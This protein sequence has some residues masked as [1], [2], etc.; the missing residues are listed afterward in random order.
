MGVFSSRNH[1]PI[2]KPKAQ[3]IEP[4]YHWLPSVFYLFLIPYSINK[5]TSFSATQPSSNSMSEQREPAAPSKLEPLGSGACGTVWSFRGR[6]TVFK[7]DSCAKERALE[8]DFKAF[9][10][11]I[12]AFHDLV[13]M[14]HLS[15]I[16]EDPV[17]QVQIPECRR[18]IG[19][20]NE[21]WWNKNVHMFPSGFVPCNLIKSERIPSFSE[22]IKNRLVSNF[23]PPEL[24]E[25]YVMTKKA[26]EHCLIRPYLYR[27]R[28][29]KAPEEP[30]KQTFSLK[31]F[32]LHKD[33]M[34]ELGIKDGD[35]QRYAGIMGETLAVIHWVCELDGRG[36]EFVLAPAPHREICRMDYVYNVLGKHC[37]WILDFDQCQS[38]TIDMEGVCRAIDAFWWNHPYMP[39]PAKDSPLWKAFR[40][41]YLKLA[42]DVSI[43][44]LGK[45]KETRFEVASGFIILLEM[46]GARRD[47]DAPRLNE[48]PVWE[49]DPQFAEEQGKKAEVMD[50]DEEEEL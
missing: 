6:R 35:M 40:K 2:A 13:L 29:Q 33:Q 1:L 10:Q 19:S 50:E 32:P 21:K 25:S 39:H 8:N 16:P 48:L 47:E 43:L 18:Y 5:S 3:V 7:D 27:N 26:D 42:M 37:M 34:K 15:F 24:A 49:E 44:P 14:K 20:N 30:D 22:R 4:P 46:E 12:N 11:I 28:P 36:I 45:D 23:C 31:N 17:P 41:Q 9:Q 38:I